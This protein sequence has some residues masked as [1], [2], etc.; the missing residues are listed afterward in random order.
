MTGDA[1]DEEAQLDKELG[2]TSL[3][4]AED[5]QLHTFH[6]PLYKTHHRD[7]LVIY[8]SVHTAEVAEAWILRNCSMTLSR[9]MDTA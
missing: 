6:C 1:L 7:E 5:D 9:I 2:G 3:S 4:T 8:V